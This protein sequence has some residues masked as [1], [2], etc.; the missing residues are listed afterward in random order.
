MMMGYN[1]EKAKVFSQKNDPQ[2]GL[3]WVHVRT[4]EGGVVEVAEVAAAVG[5]AEPVGKGKKNRE[6]HQE[7]D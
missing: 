7:L 3:T 5:V 4:I 1:F 6:L 2:S